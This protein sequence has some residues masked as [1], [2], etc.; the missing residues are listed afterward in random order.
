MEGIQHCRTKVAVRY[1]SLL[2]KKLIILTSKVLTSIVDEFEHEFQSVSRKK[3][4]HTA[5]KAATHSKHVQRFRE[6]LNETRA[7]LTLAMVHEWYALRHYFG[8][9]AQSDP[10]KRDKIAHS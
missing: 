1:R 6:S 9:P 2:L 4:W 8:Y 3:R 5:V 10:T 7:T